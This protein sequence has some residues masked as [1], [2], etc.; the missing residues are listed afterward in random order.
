MPPSGELRITDVTH[1]AMLLN[2]D[3][4]PGPV[5]KYIITY[6]AEDSDAKEV[7]PHPRTSSAFSSSLWWDTMHRKAPC[8]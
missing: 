8:L 7:R 1:S 4:A 2:W 3:A 5:R 6:K